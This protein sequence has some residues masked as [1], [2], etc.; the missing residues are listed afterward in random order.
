M[1]LG[2]TKKRKAS[3]E[4]EEISDEES[5]EESESEIDHGSQAM[6]DSEDEDLTCN[7]VKF[8]KTKI[9]FRFVKCPHCGGMIDHLEVDSDR[10]ELCPQ[11][12]WNY[13]MTPQSAKAAGLVAPCKGERCVMKSK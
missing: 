5:A 7:A 3:E 2:D 13:F 12:G 8:D 6:T 4:P 1:A 10:G 11:C 9:R